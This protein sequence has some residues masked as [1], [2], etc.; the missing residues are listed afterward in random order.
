MNVYEI[1]TAR[2]LAQ[3]EQGVIPWHQPWRSGG[4]P[5]NL[6]SQKPYRGVNVWLLVSQPY[7]SPYWL[8]FVQAQEIG[9]R[10]RPGEKGTPV[11]FWKRR[12]E[13]QEEES[14]EEVEGK[15]RAP[16][17]RYY[18]VFNTD[19]CELPASLTARLSIPQ[20]RALAPLPACEHVVQFM[21]KRPAIVHD[22]PRAY[23]APGTDVVNVPAPHLFDR[24]EGYFATLFHELTH[25]TGH[26]SRLARPS[27]VNRKEL[28]AADYSKEE[29][30]AEM[31]A[32][33]LCGHCGIESATVDNSAAYIRSWLRTLQN[34]T[35]LV[36]HAATQAQQ[37]MDFILDR[38]DVHE[39]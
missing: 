32:A 11:I 8:T 5:K 19:Q 3:L 14:G 28:S 9:G 37:A 20:P 26:V 27:V 7:T 23:Y 4:V 17:L 25:S 10:V 21:P 33:F 15:R 39:P 24:A 38:W 30:V 13:T 18:I 22:Y 1:I 2:I 6:L 29:L 16:L 36:I 35:R 12:E 34:D 31:G